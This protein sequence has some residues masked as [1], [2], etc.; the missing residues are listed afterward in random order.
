MS[1]GLAAAGKKAAAAT[2]TPAPVDL[3]GD[4]TAND[5]GG[6]GG[7]GLPGRRRPKGGGSGERK[8]RIDVPKGVPFL[9][10]PG[11]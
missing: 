7:V 3:T 11:I 4:D 9:Y 8:L 1:L 10:H 6:V 2:T 5:G